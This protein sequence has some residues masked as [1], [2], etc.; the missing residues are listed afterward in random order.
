MWTSLWFTYGRMDT[1]KHR[2][3]QYLNVKI[4]L[5]N[6]WKYIVWYVIIQHMVAKAWNELLITVPWCSLQCPHKNTY[7]T[8]EMAC[9]ALICQWKKQQQWNA[10]ETIHHFITLRNTVIEWCYCPSREYGQYSGLNI[11]VKHVTHNIFILETGRHKI[12]TPHLI[13]HA[14]SSVPVPIVVVTLTVL[15]V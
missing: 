12:W 9:V 15:T 8:K 1:R 7:D 6:N 11:F 13:Q 4:A 3:Q 10:D 14:Y 5:K 2:Q